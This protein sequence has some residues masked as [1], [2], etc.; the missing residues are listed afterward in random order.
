MFL[1]WIIMG[2]HCKPMWAATWQNQQNEF[3]PSEDSVQPGHLPSLIRVFTVRM[4]KAWVL[5]YQLSAQRRLWSDW[6]DA[7]ADMSLRLAHNHFFVFFISQL[8]LIILLLS[9]TIILFDDKKCSW[10]SKELYLVSLVC[11]AVLDFKPHHRKPVFA[12]CEQQRRRSACASAPSD[13]CLC[14]SL[15]R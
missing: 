3:A 13:Q 11:T 12:I 7:Q 8:L 14:N 4:K 5:S 10:D 6:A 9:D 15:P 2:I 1:V